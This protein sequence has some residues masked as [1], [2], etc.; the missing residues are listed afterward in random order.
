MHFFLQSIIMMMVMICTTGLVQSAPIKIRGNHVLSGITY[1]AKHPDGSC[2]NADQVLQYVTRFKKHG[3]MNIRTYS[4][5][6]NQLPNIIHAITSVDP[7][8]SVTAAVWLDGTAGDDEEISTLL[9]TLKTVGGEKVRQVVKNIMVGNEVIYSGTLSSSA[10]VKRIQQV[11]K[12]TSSYGVPVGTVDTPTTFPSNVIDASD[13]IGVNIH[14]YFGGVAISQ[15]GANL[16]TQY[17]AFVNNKSQGKSVFVSE[18][19]WPSA[20]NKIGASVPSVANLQSYVNQM[21][22]MSIPYFYFEAQD[23]NWKGAGK[24]GVETHWGLYDD[25]GISKIA[26]F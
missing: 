23:A 11:K 20:G 22:Q 10:L 8:M 18:T 3:I 16:M 15:A 17:K 2:H 24:D 1:T 21:R 9:E 4:Q 25:S 12:A 13:E 19:G 26:S 6:C 7:S 5:E 14:P